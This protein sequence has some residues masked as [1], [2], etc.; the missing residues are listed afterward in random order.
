M[1][2]YDVDWFSSIDWDWNHQ[3]VLAENEDQIRKFMDAVCKPEF[4]HKPYSNVA[5]EDSL[6]IEFISQASFPFFIN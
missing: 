4:R 5:N 2:K 6:R 1:N 3:E